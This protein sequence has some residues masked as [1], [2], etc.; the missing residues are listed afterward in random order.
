MPETES[1]ESPAAAGTEKIKGAK[2]ADG[3]TPRTLSA[4]IERSL[5][6][7]DRLMKKSPDAPAQQKAMV[8]LE[9]AKVSALLELADAIRANRKG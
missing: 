7:V 2:S 9:Q 4:R 3:G 8:Q 5:K 1:T 6:D